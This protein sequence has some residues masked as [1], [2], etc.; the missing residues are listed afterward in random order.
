MSKKLLDDNHPD[1]VKGR[2]AV[3]E[4]TM[5]LLD[6]VTALEG[7]I[8]DILYQRAFDD[9]VAWTRE[10]FRSAVKTASEV[11][12]ELTKQL[13]LSDSEKITQKSILACVT[14]NPGL[15]TSDITTRIIAT[16]PLKPPMSEG[17]IWLNINRLKNEGKI[18]SKNGRWY[19]SDIKRPD[20][21][22]KVMTYMPDGSKYLGADVIKS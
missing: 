17:S 11:E 19:S 20:Q 21:Q 4:A 18:E 1:L 3:T 5:G 8:A 6:A 7:I 22:Y 15:R 2:Q 13:E 10:R 14:A 9:G 12:P 16:V